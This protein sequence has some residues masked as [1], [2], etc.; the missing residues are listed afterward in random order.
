MLV[1]RG[2]QQRR[3]RYRLEALYLRGLSETFAAREEREALQRIAEAYERLAKQVLG[4][5]VRLAAPAT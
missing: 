4:A 5:P 1:D 3:D 2:N